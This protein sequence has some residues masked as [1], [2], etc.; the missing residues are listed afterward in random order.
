[1]GF[2]ADAA[3][4]HVDQL[5][6]GDIVPVLHDYIRIPNVSVAY[7][8]G[9]HEAGHMARATELLHQWCER[10]VGEG[11]AGA[12]V[13]VHEL[14]GRT[15]LLLIDVPPTD[16]AGASTGG[17]G[18]TVLLYGHLDK[19]PPFTGWRDGLGPWD[20]VQDGDRLYGRGAADDGYAAFAALTAVESLQAQ[21][22]VEVVNGV[23]SVVR[24]MTSMPLEQ[25][26]TFAARLSEVSIQELLEVRRGLEVEAASLAA[27]RAGAAEIAGLGRLVDSMAGSLREPAVFADFDTAFHVAIARASRNPMLVLLVEAIRVPLR[28]SVEEGLTNWIRTGE[29]DTVRQIHA[30]VL[31]A[32]RSGDPDRAA[33]AMDI[34]FA[35]AMQIIGQAG[36]PPMV[37]TGV[38]SDRRT[39]IALDPARRHAADGDLRP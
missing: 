7:D 1:M 38:P 28:R 2:D 21:G 12:S 24:G 8:A 15:P 17:D 19:Q 36:N 11:L 23:G 27:G 5:W 34:H 16:A 22:V 20:P 33:K 14:D 10:H 35:Q 4:R 3:A 6:D 37:R 26:F 31:E 9:W 13:E 30:D 18:D 25:F 32:I 29:V 39:G